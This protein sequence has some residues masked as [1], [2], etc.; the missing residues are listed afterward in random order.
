MTAVGPVLIGRPIANTTLH[1]LDEERQPVPVGVVG[2]LYIGGD[3][4]TIGYHGRPALTSERFVPDPFSATSGARMYRTGDLARWRVTDGGGALECLGRTDFQVKVRGYRIELGEIEVALS[5]HDAV[6][7]A[8]VVAREDRPGD[9]RLV[10]Y[11]VPA[12]GRTR[13]GDAE[14]RTHL[15]R[16][17]PEYMLPAHVVSLDTFPLTGSGKVDRKALP[18]PVVQE[19]A[20]SSERVEGT[21]FEERIAQRFADALAVA[22]VSIH[23]DFFAAGG[24]SLLAAQL[25]AR[26]GAELGR[27]VPMRVM[28]EHPTAARLAHWLTQADTTSA[29]AIATRIQH[30]P[31]LTTA[32]LSLM[33]QRVW[34]LEQMQPGRTVFNV[35]SAHRLLGAL[36]LAAFRAAF[37]GVVRNQGALRT[38]IDI[39][40]GTGVQQIV[41][42]VDADLELEDLSHYAPDA[43]AEE[44][45]LRLQEEAARVFDLARGPLYSARLF[46]LGVFQHGRLVGVREQ[47]VTAGVFRLGG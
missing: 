33:Q 12:A 25:V 42:H 6:A 11:I 37:N 30:Q 41:A 45:D 7:Q 9:V 14:L 4:V 19:A 47:L 21:P 2:E 29:P 38:V 26:L 15:G 24:H 23:D 32:P 1:V 36:D 28:F 3:G 31:H 40:D 39:A 34:Y 35:P 16:T 43:R 5:R 46:R 20:L 8:V 10:A 17:L 22:R 13:P 18:E 27:T 44:L